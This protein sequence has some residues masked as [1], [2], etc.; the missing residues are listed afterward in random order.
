MWG[1]ME[2]AIETR[3]LVRRYGA[4]EALRGLNLQ[5]AR[6]RVTGFLG[7]NG[8]GKST[9]IRTLLGMTRPDSGTGTVLGHAIDDAAASLEIR[10]RVAYVG[11]DKELYGYM[12]VEEL[13][14]FTASFYPD[15]R[16]DAARHLQRQYQLQPHRRVRDLSKGTRTKL[17]LL[18]AL[19]RR[20][21]LLILD[22]PTEGLDPVSIEDLLRAIGSAAADGTTVFFSSHQVADVERVADDVCIVHYGKAVAR[23]ALDEMRDQYR[24]VTLG[25]NTQVPQMDFEIP[26]VLNVRSE[27]RQIVVR[28]NG[29]AEAVVERA[30]NLEAVS[31]DVAPVSLLDVF[32]EAVGE[33]R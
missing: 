22:E 19:A 23:F 14:R 24:R 26:G 13:I 12:T 30:R 6:N 18:L 29:N 4:V 16:P 9:T 1:N 20:A 15:W 25:F 11:E 7:R 10:R 17:A 32:L 21:E 27:G 8:A 3:N 31:V 28:A 33:A 5:V 2:L